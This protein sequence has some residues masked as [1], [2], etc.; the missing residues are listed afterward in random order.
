MA[1]YTYGPLRGVV[2]GWQVA[3]LGANALH[4]RNVGLIAFTSGA[5]DWARRSPVSS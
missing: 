1:R 5:T 4:G 3:G 2:S